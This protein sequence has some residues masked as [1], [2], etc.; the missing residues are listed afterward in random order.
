MNEKMS[1]LWRQ[2]SNCRMANDALIYTQ[3]RRKH[4]MAHL[5]V[6]TECKPDKIA[7][8]Y[9]AREIRKTHD[10]IGVADSMI[11]FIF[12]LA[13]FDASNKKT[14]E[15]LKWF[16]IHGR[17]WSTKVRMAILLS[18]DEAAMAIIH[19]ARMEITSYNNSRNGPQNR[20][21]LGHMHNVFSNGQATT[22]SQRLLERA[23]CL[24]PEDILKYRDD[25]QALMR[26][27]DIASI[28]NA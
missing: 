10:S 25:R 20:F 7:L 5:E 3:A 23:L 22:D 8:A 12:R 17:Y 27:I 13:R 24:H 28:M 18:L 26:A 11:D 1:A 16:I 19:Q 21:W 15:A 4:I 2:Q 9:K 14:E 6:C